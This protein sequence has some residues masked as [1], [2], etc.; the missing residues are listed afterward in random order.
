MTPIKAAFASDCSFPV[1]Q[2]GFATLSQ[3]LKRH[4]TPD[5]I[6]IGCEATGHYGETVLRYLQTHKYAV[7]RLNPAQV[8][9]FRRGLGR[10]AKT[11][12]LDAD[13]IARQLSV[14]PTRLE[15]EMQPTSQALQHL[16]RLRLD[17][18]E[19]QTRWVSRL[20]GIL[21]QTF[22]ELEVLHKNVL[23]P[24]SLALLSTYPSRQSI[25][26]AE[27]P[28]LIAVLRNTSHGVRG[29]A[30]ARQLQTLPRTSVGLDAPWLVIELRLVVRQVMSLV[31]TIEQ[32]ENEIQGLIER[33]LGEP[34]VAFKHTVPLRLADFPIHSAL[35][36]GTLLG[37][38]GSLER[39]PSFKHLLGYIGWCPQTQ[40]SGT[41]SHPHP[42]FSKRGN[43]FVRRILWSMAVNAIRWLPE[44]RA[45]FQQRLA[46][47]KSKMNTV[48][49]VGRKLLSVF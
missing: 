39:F 49:A 8:V 25:A 6:L 10:C 44:Y 4:G 11:D 45:Y 31:E 21:N 42:K 28:E 43:R 37:E 18:V 14:S 17:F 16:T 29:A 23:C 26:E 34:Q 12:V 2:Q 19:E 7:V 1:N 30:F 27:E 48:I 46:A 38:L 36:V 41:F 35:S 15:P 24:S 13:A 9:Q 32:L 5:T 47:G 33:W 20:R 40:E 22:P 3:C